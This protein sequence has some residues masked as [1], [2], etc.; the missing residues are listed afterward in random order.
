MTYYGE[1]R[2]VMRL[3]ERGRQ[4]VV[5]ARRLGRLGWNPY[6]DDSSVVTAGEMV[7]NG[8]TIN[9]SMGRL[10]LWVQMTITGS[11]QFIWLLQFSQFHGVI[12]WE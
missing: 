8:F 5:K 7:S 6:G 4:R 9:F 11:M 10:S 1:D 12:S 3:D 2:F